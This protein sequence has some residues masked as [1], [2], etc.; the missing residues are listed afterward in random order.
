MDELKKTKVMIGGGAMAGIVASACCVGP[1]IL[2]IMG[3]S[4]AAALSKLE[5]LRIPLIAVVTLLFA[6][7]GWQLYRKKNTCEPDSLCADPK[8]TKLM[9]M[10]YWVGL[11]VAFAG[12]TSQYWIV[13]IM[14]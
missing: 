8:K 11:I 2:T 3:V 9:T 7:A 5:F 1:L 10:G 14:D 13:Y 12:I 6:Y 4:G